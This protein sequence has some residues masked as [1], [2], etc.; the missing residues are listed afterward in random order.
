MET[1]IHPVL[2]KQISQPSQSPH[3]PSFLLFYYQNIFLY[4]R[5]HIPAL[6]DWF[7]CASWVQCL[8]ETTHRNANTS[9]GGKKK[10]QPKKPKKIPKLPNNPEGR[11]E[12]K[13]LWSPGCPGSG[14]DKGSSLVWESCWKYM[15]TLWA[16][17]ERWFFYSW[18]LCRGQHTSA[19][20]PTCLPEPS[21]ISLWYRWYWRWWW[22]CCCCLWQ[23][24]L[25][26]SVLRI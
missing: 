5:H 23:L 24:S 13:E 2:P 4:Q 20:G 6:E 22:Y 11:E 16:Q 1:Q 26:F 10:K 15:G 25:Y 18:S 8:Q 7:S 14:M 17:G 21:S 9:P 3:S 19:K 12:R